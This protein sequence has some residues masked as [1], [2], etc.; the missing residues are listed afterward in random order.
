MVMDCSLHDRFEAA[1]IH[2]HCCRIKLQRENGSRWF[3]DATP[4]DCYLEQHREWGARKTAH[5]EEIII[6]PD[7]SLDITAL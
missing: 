1:A 5:G 4:C 2:R 3:I 6:A 7:Q